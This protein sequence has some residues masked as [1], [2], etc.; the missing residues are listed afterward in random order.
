MCSAQ[1]DLPIHFTHHVLSRLTIVVKASLSIQRL[2]E[3]FPITLLSL[4][5][6]RFPLQ[7]ACLL[8]EGLL[9]G[10]SSNSWLSQGRDWSVLISMEHLKTIMY[11]QSDLFCGHCLR[12]IQIQKYMFAK[13]LV[14]GFFAP[15]HHHHPLSLNFQCLNLSTLYSL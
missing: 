12:C 2:D 15:L 10:A 14:C 11:P 1:S 5:S 4:A 3:A 8:Y 9:I 7:R 6:Q 13:I